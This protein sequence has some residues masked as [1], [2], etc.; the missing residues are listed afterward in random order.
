MGHKSSIDQI[1]YFTAVYF[2]TIL[3]C[4][5]TNTQKEK[6]KKGLSQREALAATQ[7]IGLV[8]DVLKH[9]GTKW[10]T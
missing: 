2:E 1:P 8:L 4:L 9:G 7:P 6:G 10:L 5:Y 3:S